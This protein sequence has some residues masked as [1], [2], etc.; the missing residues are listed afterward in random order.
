MTLA[1]GGMNQPWPLFDS[2]LMLMTTTDP[3]PF[4]WQPFP[5]HPAAR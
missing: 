1:F 5:L 3:H 2:L 4:E